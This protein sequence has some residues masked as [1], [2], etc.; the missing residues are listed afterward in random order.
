MQVEF[1]AVL[2]EPVPPGANNFVRLFLFEYEAIVS[3]FPV[4]PIAVALYIQAGQEIAVDEP[5][6]PEAA[7]T[8]M[9]LSI[10]AF[11]ASEDEGKS[12]SQKVVYELPPR[13]ML[14]TE[15]LNKETLFTQ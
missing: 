2:P 15:I 9:F 3:S 7:K 6:L 5:E 14:I 13:L 12:P 11:I 8:E 1:T 4:A 10:A